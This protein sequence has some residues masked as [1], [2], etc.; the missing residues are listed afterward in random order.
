M[1]EVKK[2]I[3]IDIDKYVNTD[4]GAFLQDELGKGSMLTIKEPTG[5]AKVEYGDYTTID[6]RAIAFISQYLK[7]EELGRLLMLTRDLK[8]PLNI[9]YNGPRP[10]TNKTLQN[11]IEFKSEPMFHRFIKKLMELGIIYQIKGKILGEIRVIYMM[12][13]NVAKKRM[14][15]D[16][17]LFD[18][19]EPIKS[20]EDKG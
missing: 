13:P 10:H 18:I 7:K 9:I 11:Y 19:F 12:N 1:K 4:T 20:L 16:R 17:V 6:S 5:E 3:P 15:F 14:V 2:N 8:T